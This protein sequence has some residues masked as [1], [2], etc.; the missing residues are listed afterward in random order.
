MAGIKVV[1]YVR[2]KDVVS[3][4]EFIQDDTKYIEMGSSSNIGAT[5]TITAIDNT[6]PKKT[7]PN[8]M[9]KTVSFSGNI[10]LPA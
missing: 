1:G 10:P 5:S 2:H 6:Q 4:D 9:T 8:N 7:N 3:N